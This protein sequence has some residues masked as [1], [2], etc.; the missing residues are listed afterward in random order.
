MAVRYQGTSISPGIAWGRIVKLDGLALD[1]PQYAP[2]DRELEAEQFNRCHQ[3][4]VQETRMMLEQARERLGEAEAAILDAQLTFLQD[5]YSVV[6]PIRTAI[7]Q[8]GRNLTQAIDQ[9]MREI[10]DIFGQADDE[11]MRQRAGDAED[12]R[13]RLLACGLGVT[14]RRLDNLPDGTVLVAWELTPSDTIRLDLP[15]I[16]A[17][18]T[19]KG[20]YYAHVGIIARNQG[21]PSVSGLE[22][23]LPDLAEGEEILVNGDTGEVFAQ[24]G[25]AEREIFL[26]LRRRR[27][28]EEEALASFRTAPSRSADGMK[29][30]ICANIGNGREAAAA[31]Q[32]GAEGIGLLRSEFLYMDCAQL[33]D[34]ETQYQAYRRALEDMAGRPVIIRTLDIGGDKAL[35]ALPM[36]HEDNPF[37]GCRAIRLCLSRPEL[38]RTQLRA[39]LRA[40]VHGQLHIMFPM[41]SSLGELR[42]A[43]SLLAQ[44]RQELEE[45][46]IP[47]DPV[48]VG[49]MVEIPAA[50]LLADHFA[51]E[52]DFFSIGTNDLIQYTTAAERGNPQVEALYTPY[53]PAVLRLIAMTARA[54]RAQG[55]L[56]GMCGEAAADPVLLPL[57]WGMG[58]REFSMSAGNI[59][60]ARA[61]LAGLDTHKCEELAEQVADCGCAEAVKDLLQSWNRQS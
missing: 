31:V 1:I 43:K 40:S 17:I 42:Q 44:V 55:I 36:E 24:P 13:R 23:L 56:C 20:G 11:Y 54:A 10:A 29:G 12:I 32:A 22:T 19:A 35:A 45:E 49:I 26:S 37:L 61:K 14:E 51:R 47:T 57:F 50:A 2:E 53:H 9:V 27:Q 30:L 15:H 16:S 3:Q 58:I 28:E 38:F 52:V 4:A 34:E 33:P 48:Q 7:L 8:D 59:L 25:K 60:N 39:L 18:L 21:I 41:I 46:G 6:E 5:E